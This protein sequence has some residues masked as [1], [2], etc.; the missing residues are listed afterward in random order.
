MRLRKTNIITL[1]LFI[2]VTINL[3]AQQNWTHKVRIAGNPLSNDEIGSIINKAKESFVF[4]IEID[5]DITGR[6]ESF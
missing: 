5:N 2:C 6:Y 4:G 1:I 3:S